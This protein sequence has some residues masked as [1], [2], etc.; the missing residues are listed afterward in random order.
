MQLIYFRFYQTP[1]IATKLIE[2]L[3]FFATNWGLLQGLLSSLFTFFVSLYILISSNE[4]YRIP[5]I[6]FTCKCI[7]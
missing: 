4:L 7:E 3:E 2:K 5:L 6:L 1:I